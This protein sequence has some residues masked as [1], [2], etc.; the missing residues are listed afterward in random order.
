MEAGI[1]F[2]KRTK[3]SDE[4][5]I[6]AVNSNKIHYV[7]YTIN[8]K[9]LITWCGYTLADWRTVEQKRVALAR[10]G[11]CIKQLEK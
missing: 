6:V 8:A 10:C 1:D 4:A 2:M 11:K 7:K 3:I 5:Q 9:H